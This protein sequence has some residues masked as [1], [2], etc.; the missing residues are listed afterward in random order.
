[1]TRTVWMFTVAL[2]CWLL[3]S[4]SVP[5]PACPAASASGNCAGILVY[6]GGLWQLNCA[7]GC[8]VGC[9]TSATQDAYGSPGYACD[10]CG[11]DHPPRCC[12]VVLLANPAGASFAGNCHFQTP[13]CPAGRY[14]ELHSVSGPDEI[15]YTA[16]CIG[17][18]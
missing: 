13:S 14:C 9:T 7:L 16:S 4:S 1:M 5:A 10:E 8:P 3:A 15:V 18:G 2:I 12:H 11:T 17:S 6:S